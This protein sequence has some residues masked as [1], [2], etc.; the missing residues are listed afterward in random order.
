METLLVILLVYV[1]G[2]MIAF[3]CVREWKNPWYEKMG[4]ISVWPCTLL[5]YIYHKMQGGQ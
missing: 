5:L 1:A 4:A 3:L 2:A